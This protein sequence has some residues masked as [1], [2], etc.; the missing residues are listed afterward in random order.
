MSELDAVFRAL[1]SRR[2]R[3]TLRCLLRHRDL[4]LPDLAELVAEQER[5]EDLPAIPPERVS[6]V[7]FSLYHTHLPKLEAADLV[8]YE[9]EGDYVATTDRTIPAL[10]EGRDALEQLTSE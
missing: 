3:I 10:A 7:Y 8:R 6:R 9:Q 1:A 5:A 4:T 2:R